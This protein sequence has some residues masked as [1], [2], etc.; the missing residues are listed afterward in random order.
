MNLKKIVSEHY[1]ED[2]QSAV[3]PVD[4]LN[5][6]YELKRQ[7][8]LE[9]F[10]CI[11]V[12]TDLFKKDNE[13]IFPEE[14]IELIEEL[15]DGYK[16]VEMKAIRKGKYYEA[17]AEYIYRLIL[18]IDT[19]LIDLDTSDEVRKIQ[20]DYMQRKMD[21]MLMVRLEN[22]GIRLQGLFRNISNYTQVPV[23]KLSY[24]ERCEYLD[25]VDAEIAIFEKMAMEKF[26]NIMHKKDNEFK[27]NAIKIPV[28]KMI[29]SERSNAIQK[30]LFENKEYQMLFHEQH[31]LENNKGFIKDYEKKRE[32]ILNKLRR[33]IKETEDKVPTNEEDKTELEKLLESID[34]S[35]VLSYK[36][37]DKY[38]YAEK[39]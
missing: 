2:I 14:D 19:L 4:R 24:D 26:S 35:L 15:L 28:E 31:E 11:G 1:K 16:D 21:Y 10:C 13:Y 8:L 18:L 29:Q 32:K 39:Q 9:I 30:M 37:G 20:V 12:I 34:G 33:I 17:G 6:L 3:S 5:D 36:S 27:E 7:N 22:I 25:A 38:W 23:F